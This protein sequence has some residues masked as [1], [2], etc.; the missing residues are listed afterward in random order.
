MNINKAIKTLDSK[1]LE[2]K[3]AKA[4]VESII[5][6]TSAKKAYIDDLHEINENIDELSE[7]LKVLRSAEAGELKLCEN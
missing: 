6:I 7:A 1:L 2:Y 5:P 4:R 3:K